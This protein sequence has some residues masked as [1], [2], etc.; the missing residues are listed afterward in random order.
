MLA[1]ETAK[2][3]EG[4]A[5]SATTS[6]ATKAKPKAGAHA[7]SAEEAAQGLPVAP[8]HTLLFS[9]V[10]PFIEHAHVAGP[11]RRGGGKDFGTSAF[12]WGKQ[13][14]QGC[15]DTACACAPWWFGMRGCWTREAA[16]VLAMTSFAALNIRRVQSEA[17]QR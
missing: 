1:I 7:A 16:R 3:H 8:V 4:R 12:W 10:P 17:N 9:H 5:A 2:C 13:Y 6:A 14:A 15:A 11:L